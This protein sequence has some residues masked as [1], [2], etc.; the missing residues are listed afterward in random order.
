MVRPVLHVARVD[1]TVWA[2]SPDHA[3][4]LSRQA[5]NLQGV[6]ARKVRGDNMSR[7]G[8]DCWHNLASDQVTNLC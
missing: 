4:E 5:A 2:G 8:G 3:L 1:A 6:K 7:L